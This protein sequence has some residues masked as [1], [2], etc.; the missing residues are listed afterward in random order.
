[1]FNLEYLRSFR[2]IDIAIFD[3]VVS[4]IG[5]Y[6]VSP[7]LIRFFRK[8]KINTTKQTWLWLMFPI[9]VVVHL[10]VGQQTTLVK[11]IL[12]PSNYFA[13]K[14]IILFMIIMGFKQTKS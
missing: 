10:L 14:L 4:Y 12:D 11:M 1:M 3:V 9:S 7:L 2:I 5:V 6:L 13:I 8:F